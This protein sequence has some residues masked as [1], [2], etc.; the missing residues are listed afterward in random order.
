V[1][2]RFARRWVGAKVGRWVGIRNGHTVPAR[3]ALRRGGPHLRT[4]AP[5]HLPTYRI[6]AL[7]PHFLLDRFLGTLAPFARASE[8]PIAIACS[9]LFTFG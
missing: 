8:R 4:Y 9:R 6:E 7:A 3:C 5:T 2:Q 1:G